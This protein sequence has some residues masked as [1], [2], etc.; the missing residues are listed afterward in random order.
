MVIRKLNSLKKVSS[1]PQSAQSLHA[2]FE[3]SMLKRFSSE[4]VVVKDKQRLKL[5]Y[6]NPAQRL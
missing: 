5:E 6:K 1:K 2:S 4:S 3:E